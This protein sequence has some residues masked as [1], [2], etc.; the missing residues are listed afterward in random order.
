MP[1]IA[2]DQSAP[3]WHVWEPVGI[4]IVTI[5]HHFRLQPQIMSGHLISS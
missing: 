1:E 5:C 3:K 2:T 4:E